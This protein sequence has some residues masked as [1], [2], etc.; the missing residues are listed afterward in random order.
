MMKRIWT[1]FKAR[2]LEFLRDRSAFAW[3]ILFPILVIV[4]F[5]VLFNDERQI[6]YKIGVI[7]GKTMQ[8][9]SKPS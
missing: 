2:N 6:L 1:L 9:H 3:N 5:S 4:G 7:S 8:T